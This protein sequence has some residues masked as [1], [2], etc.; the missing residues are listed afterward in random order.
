MRGAITHRHMALGRLTWSLAVC[1][2]AV[3][4][5]ALAAPAEPEP[6]PPAWQDA[7]ANVQAGQL[8]VPL[9][10]SQMLTVDRPFG[11]IMVGNDEIA[12]I[13][14]ITMRS[15]YVLGRKLGTT[16]LTI[17]D[18]AN[19]VIAVVDVAVG[20][21]VVSLRRQMAQLMPND[22]IGAHIS[23]DA[24]VLTGLAS[25]APAI[26]RAVQLA[27]TYSGDKVVNMV[28][29]G[30]SQQVMLE[31]RFSEVRRDT[32]K[33][34]GIGAFL[35]SAS[36]RFDGVFGNGAQLV[37]DPD[38]GVGIMQRSAVTDTFG[39]FRQLFSVG[40]V[41]IEGT[42]DALESKGLIKTLAQPTLIALSGETASFLAGGEFPIPVVQNGST[43]GNAAQVT[44]EF[45]P[46]GVSLA[47]TPTVLADG[48]I[49]LNVEPEVSSL[50]S[51]A[52]VQINGLTIPG[53]RTRRASTVLELRDGEAF[54]IAGLLQQDFGTTVRQLPLLG[55]IPIIGTLFRSSGFKRGETELVIIVIPRLVQPTRA[56]QIA[57]P[58]DRVK[59]PR[60]GD[61]FLMGRTD[62][63][64]GVNPF[65]PHEPPPTSTGPA[66]AG[67]GAAPAK[68]KDGY[69]Y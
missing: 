28:S 42:L 54:A 64:V 59:D 41:S 68:G 69:A 57:L 44:V 12:D 60:E 3:A 51:S 18:K 48:V 24:I 39:V 46:F 49:S 47:F 13:Q 16:S 58:T 56:D 36:G 65:D 6:A 7:G 27:R 14:P 22:R 30:A 29:V 45:K 61:L 21:D 43:T 38:T 15:V 17:Y 10:K 31:V 33:N 20:P 67:R 63:A 53:L 5:Q 25:S 34:I 8:E 35:N 37:P 26:D 66:P 9:N 23:N 55:S 50:D 4:G 32:A 40:G 62:R 2:A 19:R 52:S 11:R 1:M